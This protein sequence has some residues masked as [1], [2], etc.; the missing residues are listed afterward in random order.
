MENIED[1]RLRLRCQINEKIAAG[2]QIATRERRILQH[3]VRSEKHLLA[4]FLSHAIT[5][6]VPHKKRRNRS[7]ET[8]AS[9]IDG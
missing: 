1:L 2:N 8:S 4:H 7:G 6:V 9:I 3:I 5:A